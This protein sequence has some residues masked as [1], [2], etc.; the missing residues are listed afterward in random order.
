MP[1]LA[2]IFFRIEEVCNYTFSLS[3]ENS[4]ISWEP[5]GH[6]HYPMMFCWEQEGCYCCA[7]SM[8]I[9]PFWFSMRTR[10]V[11]LLYKVNGDSALLVLNGTLLNSDNALLVLSRRHIYIKGATKFV[12]P[13]CTVRHV[14]FIRTCPNIKSTC[15]I[16]F[17]DYLLVYFE[18]LWYNSLFRN[19]TPK[20]IWSTRLPLWAREMNGYLPIWWFLLALHGWAS[21]VVASC[22]NNEFLNIY[23]EE[24]YRKTR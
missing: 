10:R 19:I 21:S 16:L 14:I 12:L 11:L 24:F 2:T 4:I 18:S 6:Y 8:A 1:T 7:K 17:N 5:E 23:Y 9:A 3:I 15:P 13:S 20:L 22:Y